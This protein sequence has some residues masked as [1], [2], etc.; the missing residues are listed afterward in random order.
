MPACLK[1]FP[2]LALSLVRMVYMGAV[3][4]QNK[5]GC[6]IPGTFGES[7]TDPSSIYAQGTSMWAA[8]TTLWQVQLALGEASSALFP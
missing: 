4:W 2:F 3:L 8:T 6:W 1:V 5:P 7:P